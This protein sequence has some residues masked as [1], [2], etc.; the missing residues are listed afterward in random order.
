M[1]RRLGHESPRIE[2]RGKDVAPSSS[3]DQNLAAT[4][5]GSL[6]Q[7]DLGPGLRCGDSRH[8]TGGTRADD[9]DRKIFRFHGGNMEVHACQRDIA[10]ESAARALV[11][12]PSSDTFRHGSPRCERR[13]GTGL[14]AFRIYKCAAYIS[15]SHQRTLWAQDRA[16]APQFTGQVS[17]GHTSSSHSRQM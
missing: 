8:Q 12:H 7:H 5:A 16:N 2:H 4:V 11:C 13:S 14:I 17:P 9:S 3:A 10:S 1:R 6:Q 15:I